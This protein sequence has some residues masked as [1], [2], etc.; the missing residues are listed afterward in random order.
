MNKVTLGIWNRKLTLN[1]YFKTYKGKQITE[2]QKNAYENFIISKS[3]NSSLNE[4]FSYIEKEYKD[5]LSGN[6]DNIFKYVMP[7]TIYIPNSTK[8]KTVVLLCDFKFNN[9]HGLALV[10]E[11][12]QLTKIA[13][14]D[15]IL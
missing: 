8:E 13:F 6:I 2:A 4:L 3:L 14:Q 12:E 15:E 5:K 11:K 1:V 7:N 10:F 9:E